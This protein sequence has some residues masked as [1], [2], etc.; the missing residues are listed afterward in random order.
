MNTYRKLFAYIPQ[1]KG[2]AI[3]AVIISCV[4]CILITGGYYTIYRFLDALIVDSN[5]QRAQSF[6]FVIVLLLLAGSIFLGISA[7]IAHHLSLIH[8]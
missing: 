1:L 8:I 2:L 4:S 3:L 7:L 5:L 6:A